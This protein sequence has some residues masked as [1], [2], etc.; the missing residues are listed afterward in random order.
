MST[1]GKTHPRFIAVMEFLLSKKTKNNS[2]TFKTF[3]VISKTHCSALQRHVL[4]IKIVIWLFF[5]FFANVG[6][7]DDSKWLVIVS[8]LKKYSWSS[9]ASDMETNNKWHTDAGHTS[10][11]VTGLQERPV[12]HLLPKEKDYQIIWNSYTKQIAKQ[13]PIWMESF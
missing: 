8:L 4:D 5:F 7:S 13:M 11:W 10:V 12:R 6:F 1:F 9:G 3:T 2:H